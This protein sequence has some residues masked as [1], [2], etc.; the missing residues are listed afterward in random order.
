MTTW[1]RYVPHAQMLQFLA[2]GWLIEDEFHGTNHGEYAVLMRWPF[3]GEP[4]R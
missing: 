4:P 2:E 1:L 3:E